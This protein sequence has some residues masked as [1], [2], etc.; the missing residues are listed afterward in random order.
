MRLY[1]FLKIKR[2][3]TRSHSKTPGLTMTCNWCQI[4]KN[5]T[6]HLIHL[7]CKSILRHLKKRIYTRA[8]KHL[9]RPMHLYN[10]N[11]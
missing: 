1:I 5:Y 4:P 9:H 6:F 10:N 8:K 11:T 3:A 2:E 7:I